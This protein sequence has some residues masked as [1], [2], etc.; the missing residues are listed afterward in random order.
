MARQ[1]L[2]DGAGVAVRP[3]RLRMAPRPSVT[4]ALPS[5]WTSPFWYR[6]LLETA[7]QWMKP[8]QLI[9]R[10]LDDHGGRVDAHVDH[11]L[12]SF[13]VDEL[14]PEAETTIAGALAAVGV[15]PDHPLGRIGPDGRLSL[16]LS[17]DNGSDAGEGAPEAAGNLE[18][19]LRDNEGPFDPSR[20]AGN[21]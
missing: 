2:H 1:L 18:G 11:L 10:Y 21:E 14:T 19:L 3:W 20:A 5:S 12:V 8:E 17:E 15:S 13:Q 16:R 4:L 6:P 7:R 9:R